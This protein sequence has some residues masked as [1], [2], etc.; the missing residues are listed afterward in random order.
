MS[1]SDQG[2]TIDRLNF[3]GKEYMI[4]DLTDRVKA[5]I[6]VLLKIQQDLNNLSQEVRIQQAAQ[7][8]ITKQIT[9]NIEEDKIKEV[10]PAETKVVDEQMEAAHNIIESEDK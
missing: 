3:N 4:A 9:E 5:G 7:T 1:N 2:Q 8:E 6:N 10:E